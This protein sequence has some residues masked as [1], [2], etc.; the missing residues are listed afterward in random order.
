MTE[1]RAPTEL[2]QGQARQRALRSRTVAA[3]VVAAAGGVLTAGILYLTAN[4]ISTGEA[5]NLSTLATTEIAAATQTMDLMSSPQLVAAARNCTAPL[6]Y[7]RIAK[8]P[9]TAGGP[10]RIKS[11]NYLSPPFEM[12]DAP[13]Q[14]A[15]PFPAPYPQGHGTISVE[16]NAT[17][18]VIS[19]SPA[20]HIDALNGA[21]TRN[22]IWKPGYPCQ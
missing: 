20:W 3:S 21:T 19:L 22:V 5:S 1:Q 8:M 4:N 2:Q 18:A 10:I 6:A 7:V 11:G 15:I 13:Q 14:V 17:G 12:T 16:G 9:G